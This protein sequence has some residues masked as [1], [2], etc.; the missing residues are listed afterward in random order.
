MLRNPFDTHVR[1]IHYQGMAQEVLRQTG[2]KRGTCLI[3]GCDNGHF[4]YEI[5]K[6]AK[7]LQ[8]HCIAPDAEQVAIAQR[9][10]GAAGVY[11]T[12]VHLKQ[13]D[14]TS[15]PYSASFADLILLPNAASLSTETEA[16]RREIWQKYRNASTQE[17]KELIQQ[18]QTKYRQLLQQVCAQALRVLKPSGGVLYVDLSAQSRSLSVGPETLREWMTQPP[19]DQQHD[20]IEVTN[21][22]IK[23]TRGKSG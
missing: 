20:T 13:G 19:F 5:A 17:R 16:E 22:W 12:R 8:I 9:N 15:L 10:L 18:A 2:I 6:Q 4:A 21:S 11:P 3:L 7:D 14:F 23:L 1:A